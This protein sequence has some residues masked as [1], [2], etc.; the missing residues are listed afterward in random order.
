MKIGILT[1]LFADWPL[2][3]VARH[4][5]QLG[6]EAV[7][8]PVWDGNGHAILKAI[9]GGGA[10]ALKKMLA[11]NGLSISA[12]NHGVAGQISMGPHDVSTDAWAPG[13]SPE[14][15]I[16]WP[17]EQLKSAAR[18]AADEHDYPVMSPED[19]AEKAI[20]YLRPLIIRKPLAKVW[21]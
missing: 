7:E 1:A 6:Y 14:Q 17:A 8:L 5:A 18:A 10:K 15:K 9:L 11:E 19:G 12:L 2:E 20:A 4:V 3:R 13:M 21:W 16:L